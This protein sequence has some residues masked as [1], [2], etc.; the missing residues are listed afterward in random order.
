MKTATFTYSPP[1]IIDTAPL[2]ARYA[3]LTASIFAFIATGRHGEVLLYSRKLLR[4]VRV[5]TRFEAQNILTR[6]KLE[7][8]ANAPWRELS[9]IHI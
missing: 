3:V 1:H 6:R 9:L 5:F 8:L 2:A 7:M 4:L